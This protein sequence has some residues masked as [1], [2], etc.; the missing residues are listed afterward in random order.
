MFPASD[1]GA[2]MGEPS[3]APL[4]ASPSSGDGSVTAAEYESSSRSDESV[5]SS[6]ADAKGPFTGFDSRNGVGDGSCDLGDD[7]A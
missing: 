4:D 3:P 7:V 6:I 1:D 2:G 5:R